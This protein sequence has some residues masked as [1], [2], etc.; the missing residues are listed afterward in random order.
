MS[1]SQSEKIESYFKLAVEQYV[2]ISMVF[3][4]DMCPYSQVEGLCV[5]VKNGHFITRT[6]LDELEKS[7]IIW[8]TETTGYFSVRDVDVLNFSFRTR[9]V[10]LYNSPPASMFMV[11]PLPKILD[12]EQ[13]RYSRRVN[14]DLDANEDFNVWHSYLS[15]GDNATPPQQKWQSL[16]SR[17]SRLGEISANG[18]RV[19]MEESNP[20]YPKIFINDTV[21][22]KGNFGL[23]KK[24]AELF[25]LGNIVRKMHNPE[26]ENI[27]SIGCQFTSW[28]K[29]ADNGAWFRADNHEG[30][31]Q[32]AQW[33]SR[34]FHALNS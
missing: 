7:P 17:G 26:N 32:I 29:V 5:G 11:F 25:V 12:K 27:V 23:A 8:G 3:Q 19:D 22:L 14:L 31:G 2:E 15:G 20:L 16:I 4:L 6:S 34:N 21:L 13:R 18:M 10:R 24:P 33:I 30:I 28:R 1:E 9:M